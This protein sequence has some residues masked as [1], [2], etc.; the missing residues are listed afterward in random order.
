MET[1][2]KPLNKLNKLLLKLTN[3]KEYGRYKR[4][5]VHYKIHIRR[6]EKLNNF[7]AQNDISNP[8]KIKGLAK[9]N[10]KLNF[11][12]AGNAGDIIYALPTLKAIKELTGVPINL[13]LL[14]DQPHGLDP[15]YTHPLGNVTLNVQMANLLVPLIGQ[16]DY[17]NFCA[18]YQNEEIHIKL[19]LF[20]DLPIWLD[21]GNII[22]WYNYT[23]GVLP[24]ISTPWLKVNPNIDFANNIVI[25]RSL[26]YQ[27]KH[28]TYEF[29]SKYKNLCFVGVRSEYEAISQIIPEIAFVEVKDFM[30]LAEIIAGAAFFIGNQSFPFS[31][32]E[33]LK[34][35]RILET[36]FDTPNV[37]P[38]GENGFDFLL[39]EHFE[40]HV[41]NLYNRY[42]KR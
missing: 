25:A 12:H 41:D 2:F 40:W 18:A 9:K 15:I 20:R 7:I 39:Q 34:T 31:I 22:R 21:K 38:D 3:K 37:I 42:C 26:R 14:L 24:Q 17:I 30:Q 10:G 29:L 19:D 13:Y 32:A 35:P 4:K 27:N 6:T 16:Q 5:A 23:T 11:I 36:S 28:I 1:Q 8:D 33:A